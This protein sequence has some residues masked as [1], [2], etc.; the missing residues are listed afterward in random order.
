MAGD[1][2]LRVFDVGD[3]VQYVLTL[4]R[5]LFKYLSYLLSSCF[6]S[7]TSKMSRVAPSRF[8]LH[9]MG[10]IDDARHLTLLP[11]EQ[12]WNLECPT[13]VSGKLV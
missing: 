1:N 8:E 4:L 3:A 9:K 11:F 5:T 13:Q 6:I 7:Q 2:N 12:E 10:K